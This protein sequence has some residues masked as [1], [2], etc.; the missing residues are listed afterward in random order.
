MEVCMKYAFQCTCGDV[1]GVDADTREEAIEMMKSVMTPDM[2][3]QHLFIKHYGEPAP[4]G[5]ELEL[6]LSEGVHAIYMN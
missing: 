1:V 2:M 3:S 5:E 6:M 4:E